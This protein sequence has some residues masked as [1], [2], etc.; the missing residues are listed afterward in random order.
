MKKN[1]IALFL[2]I[3]LVVC[4][5]A[6]GMGT[7]DTQDDMPKSQATESQTTESQIVESLT[8][9]EAFHEEAVL[10]E[11]TLEVTDAL[12]ELIA[13][14]AY[15]E[16]MSTSQDLRDVIEGWRDLDIDRSQPIYVIPLS[17]SDTETYL[18]SMAGQELALDEMPQ[19]VKEYLA[20][21]VGS[22]IGNIM[23]ARLGGTMVLA[24]AS[25]VNYTKTYIPEETV[26]NQVWF[27]PADDTTSLC[28]SF[29]NTGN[30]VLTV[31]AT[32]VALNREM[33]DQFFENEYFKAKE[34]RW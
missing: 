11:I 16:A 18:K 24:A 15:L 2:S 14:D 26:E 3:G 21:K 17:L 28:V 6:C 33:R 12:S 27:V 4:L 9:E 30:G 10:K 31:T 1:I 19:A 34:S 7:P 23:N 8:T 20:G 32:Y 13:C 25:V 5:G 29:S 22:S